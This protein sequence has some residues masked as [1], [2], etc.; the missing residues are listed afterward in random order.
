MK[1]SKHSIRIISALIVSAGTLLLFSACGKKGAGEA[2]EGGGGLP[3]ATVHTG[4]V[5]V[6]DVPYKFESFG[7]LTQTNSVNI[8]PQV[9][10][11]LMS[12]HFKDGQAVKE[13][14][15]LFVIDKS[16][17]KASLDKAN[18]QLAQDAATLKVNTEIMKIN[19]PLATQTIVAKQ[20]FL[21]YVKDVELGKAT[22]EYDK[23]QIELDKINLNYC[24][25]RSPLSG[26]T[27]KRQV[28]P[29]NIVTANSSTAMVNIK[30]ISPIYADFTVPEKYYFDIKRELAADNL[31]I[32]IIPEGLKGK[33][34]EAKVDF[35][36]NQISY[37]TGTISLRAT[38]ENKNLELWPGQ[39]IKVKVTLRTDKSSLTVP[40]NAIQLGKDGNYVFVADNGKAKMV[41]VV[42]GTKTEDYAQILKGDLKE[43]ERV[44]TVGV[45]LLAPGAQLIDLTSMAAAKMAG[46][47]SAPA[48][49]KAAAPEEASK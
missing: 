9:T 49:Q 39:Y 38:V 24:E 23:A 21:Q 29:G 35:I 34:F 1:N 33:S 4:T 30:S 26:I 5:S 44:V 2:H 27:G 48:A 41:P 22:V 14:D 16:E 6:R 15:L 40:V 25:I 7:S 3:P 45:L 18:A 46:A 10:G 12:V 32:E 43:G 17:Y 20:Q 37:D 42:V 13:G 47:G 31:K 8:V 28:D 11:K 19:E 36:D